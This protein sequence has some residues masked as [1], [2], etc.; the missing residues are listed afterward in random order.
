MNADP[1]YD[2]TDRNATIEAA[3]DATVDRHIEALVL[4]QVL[5]LLGDYMADIRRANEE[6]EVELWQELRR[7][8]SRH[9]E[10][11]GAPLNVLVTASSHHVHKRVISKAGL[12]RV[13]RLFSA[14]MPVLPASA[15]TVGCGTAA[16]SFTDVVLRFNV[17]DTAKL[18]ILVSAGDSVAR[19]ILRRARKLFNTMDKTTRAELTMYINRL[20]DARS[21]IDTWLC[22]RKIASSTNILSMAYPTNRTATST[23]CTLA[24]V[25][26]L[27]QANADTNNLSHA[28]IRT[29]LSSDESRSATEILE[30]HLGSEYCDDAL[31]AED[32]ARLKLKLRLADEYWRGVHDLQATLEVFPFVFSSSTTHCS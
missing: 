2:V 27:S 8:N 12:K 19:A 1:V 25:D 32:T 22:S 13:K 7:L 18:Q 23:M 20:I 15:L 16:T 21:E 4:V 28:N 5:A 11:G 3:Y 29:I 10:L 30:E 24:D 14:Q 31:A 6:Y 26:A 9:I 17:S